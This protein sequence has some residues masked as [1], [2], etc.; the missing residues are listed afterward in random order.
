MAEAAAPLPPA[1]QQ[2][3][4]TL[5]APLQQQG[6]PPATGVDAI[7]TE[8]MGVAPAEHGEPNVLGLDATFLVALSMMVLI[9]VVLWRRVPQLIAASLDNRIASIREQLDE[10][11]SLRSEAEQLRANYDA[12]IAAVAREAEGMRESARREA[13]QIVAKAQAD[14][15][16]LIARRRRMAEDRIAAAERQ[17]VADVRTRVADASAAAAA[18]LLAARMD[19]DADRQMQDRAIGALGRI[20]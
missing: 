13:E 17:A 16:A 11:R 14:T 2:E 5:D 18:R 10:A 4:R 9:A 6:L 7:E 3:A 1:S 15:D 19:A 20:N 12:K 8:H